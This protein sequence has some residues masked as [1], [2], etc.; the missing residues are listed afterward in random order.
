MR[1]CAEVDDLTDESQR[2][3][4]NTEQRWLLIGGAL[5]LGDWSQGRHQGATA[6]QR[7]VV[8]SVTRTRSHCCETR[9]AAIRACSKRPTLQS[10]PARMALPFILDPTN[11]TSVRNTSP[12][13][14]YAAKNHR[15]AEFNIEGNPFRRCSRQ[16]LSRFRRADPARPDQCTLVPDGDSQLTSDHGWDPRR[17]LAGWSMR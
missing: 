2:L 1:V 15:D 5:V 17:H 13:N 12:L 7:L 3:E 9:V 6:A 8:I 11:G 4:N 14:E 16:R 10:A